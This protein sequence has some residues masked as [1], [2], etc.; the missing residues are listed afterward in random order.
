MLQYSYARRTRRV[1][2]EGQ[3]AARHYPGHER[4][5]E[6]VGDAFP[7]RAEIGER[8]QAGRAEAERAVAETLD[9]RLQPVGL[10]RTKRDQP[11]EEKANQRALAQLQVVLLLARGGHDVEK[12]DEDAEDSLRVMLSPSM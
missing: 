5:F 7:Q 1:G 4:L 6:F 12:Q 10:Q 3:P 11:G 8:G 2:D 9:E